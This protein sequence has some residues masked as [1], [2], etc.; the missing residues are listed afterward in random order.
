MK[1]A[2]KKAL[3]ALLVEGLGDIKVRDKDIAIE[4][5]IS[6]RATYKI[7]KNNHDRYLRL[8]DLL[9]FRKIMNED[10]RLIQKES[11]CSL[12]RDG[13]WVNDYLPSWCEGN[14]YLTDKEKRNLKR[15]GETTISN[16]EYIEEL[17]N[18]KNNNS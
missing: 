14:L 15:L 7:K 5:G 3:Q 4:L 6:L 2:T 16:K 12:Y 10:V 1:Q 13:D 8:I 11:I 18:A 9:K 17:L